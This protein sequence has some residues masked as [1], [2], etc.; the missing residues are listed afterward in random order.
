MSPQD[1]QTT[2][3]DSVTIVTLC[4]DNPGELELTL[5]SIRRGGRACPLPWKVLVV[6]ASNSSAC[7]HV[8]QNSSL[9][10]QYRRQV[11]KGIY[12]AMNEALAAVDSTLLA[13]MHAGDTYVDNGLT[14]L[15]KHWLSHHRPACSFGQAWVRPKRGRSW[16]TPD[17]CVRHLERWIQWMSP[18]HQSFIFKTDFAKENPYGE[19]S[20]IAD[21]AVMKKAIREC[22]NKHVYT[23][24]PVCIY[25]LNGISSQPPNLS[26]L[27]LHLRD[28]ER[29]RWEKIAEI[30][31]FML[32]PTGSLQSH[33]MRLRSKLWGLACQ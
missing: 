30:L 22:G 15:V 7:K 23:R 28:R 16:L 11:G 12:N 10:V 32:K 21:R 17:P 8:A 25:R 9:P 27:S 1:P 18:C 31:K 29:N 3:G 26:T 20:L 4:K 6:D 19:T 24:T 33:L 5:D 13:F 14:H 2:K